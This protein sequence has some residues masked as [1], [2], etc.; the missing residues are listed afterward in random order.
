MTNL[1]DFSITFPEHFFFLGGGDLK[2]QSHFLYQSKIAAGVKLQKVGLG[3]SLLRN[4][5]EISRNVQSD[6]FW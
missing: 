4:L 2:P 1:Q 6:A 5:G 3:V